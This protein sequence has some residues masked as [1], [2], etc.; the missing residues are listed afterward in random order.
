M[1]KKEQPKVSMTLEQKKVFFPVLAGAII[2]ALLCSAN[3][4][5]SSSYVLFASK[6]DVT[7]S[8]V[9]I[10][11]SCMTAAGLVLMQFSGSFMV[12]RGARLSGLIALV[13]VAIGFLFMAFAPNVYVVW[14]G[15][16]FLGFNSA[17]GQTNVL[18]A[19]VRKWVDP[20]YQGTYMGIVTAATSI[21]GAIWPTLGGVL[22]TQMGLS[23]AFVVLVPCFMVPAVVSLLLIKDDPAACGVDPIGYD[24]DRQVTAG[25]ARPQADSNFKM[26][27]EPAFWLCA[28]GMFLTVVLTTQLSL[29]ATALQMAG[30]SAA[31]ASSIV[32]IC[33]LA[34]FVVNLFAGA[35]YDKVGLKGLTLYSYGMAAV[36]SL[37]LWFFF[38]TG[39]F[40]MLVLFVVTNALSRPYISTHI[41][42]SNAVF[43][44]N[45]SLVQPRIM[46]FY[47]LGSMVL[48]PVVSALADMWGG[49]TNMCWVWIVF[50]FI[51]IAVW[52]AAVAAGEKMRA[53]QAAAE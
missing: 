24:P 39:S 53:K 21:G 46:S 37:F 30:M 5:V 27:R 3:T 42:A 22:F 26:F 38:T 52:F 19:V 51:I 49:Y 7:T 16:L 45:A 1:A 23:T 15:Y 43:G 4:A 9:V 32:S 34:S 20:S 31:T 48:T 13:G 11:N 8:T 47:S 41:Y 50:A 18:A 36:S 29:M 6:F 25:P 17:F 12:K 2:Y 14:I 35:L 33:S 28:L 44:A 40:A 10:G